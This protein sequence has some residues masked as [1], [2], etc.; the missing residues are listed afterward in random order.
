MNVDALPLEII[1]GAELLGS[2][3]AW[4]VAAFPAAIDAARRLGYACLGGQFQFRS[5]GAVREMYWLNAES[6]PRRQGELWGN[7]AVRS[8]DETKD[9]FSRLLHETDWNHEA[10][11]WPG[12][13]SELAFRLDDALVFVAYFVTELGLR[14]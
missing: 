14:N 5:N 2:E 3:Y 9:L 7:Y 13:N 11:Q 12:L 10:S 6:S 4:N 8:C 1:A